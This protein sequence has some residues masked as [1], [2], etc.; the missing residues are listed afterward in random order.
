MHDCLAEVCHQ[1]NQSRVPFVRDLGESCRAAGHQDLPHSILKSFDAIFVD[2]DKCLGR[3]LF[4][5]LVL[6]LPHAVL[7][8]EFF[9]S[10]SLLRQD[11]HLKAAHVE[12]QIRIVFG[13]N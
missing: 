7:L 4:G 9:L 8:R 11:A 6:Q 5:A 13:V 3:D 2:S 1:A 12:E 10:C